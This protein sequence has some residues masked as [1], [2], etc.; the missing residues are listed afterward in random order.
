MH[1]IIA[2][3]YNAFQSPTPSRRLKRGHSVVALT[4]FTLGE[5]L[6]EIGAMAFAYCRSLQHIDITDAVKMIK[7]RAYD[8]CRDLT[9]VD[10]GNGLEE[11]EEGAFNECTY[12]SASSSPPLRRQL[13][14]PH[15]YDAQI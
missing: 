11:I 10:L 12:Y 2:Q 9:T 13:M 8:C 14:T 3:R 4:T 5:E 7:R 15:S 6:E 1:L